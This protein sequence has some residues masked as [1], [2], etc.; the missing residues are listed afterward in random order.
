MAKAYFLPLSSTDYSVALKGALR[1]RCA[2]SLGLP[3]YCKFNKLLTLCVFVV[4]LDRAVQQKF[5]PTKRLNCCWSIKMFAFTRKQRTLTKLL[6]LTGLLSCLPGC[7]SWFVDEHFQN[8]QVQLTQVEVVRARALE[9]E[10]LFRYRIDNP[11]DAN[12]TVRGLTYRVHLE[13]IEITNGESGIWVEVPANG[14]AYYEVPVHTNLW[15]NMKQVVRLLR[16][17][18]P[19]RYRLDGELKSGLVFGRRLPVAN[20]GELRNNTSSAL[21]MLD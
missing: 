20:D 21:S 16:K 5:L 7:S 18:K 11:N 10:F 8:P 14:H 2:E 19:I 17:D 15:R 1:F 13:D 3:N 6:L 4:G 9:Q 12:L